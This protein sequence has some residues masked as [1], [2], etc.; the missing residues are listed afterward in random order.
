VRVTVIGHAGLYIESGDTTVLVDPWL[1]GSC[2]WRSWWHFPP[3]PAPE[4]RWLNPTYLYLTHHHFDHFHYPSLRRIHRRA[5]V[6]IPRF[7]NDV[8]PTELGRLG[9]GDVVE[10]DHGRTHH[11]GPVELTSFQYGFDDSALVVA[12]RDATVFDLNDCK[13][14]PADLR[15][16]RR[17]FGR[18]TLMLK[19]HSWAQG[20][21]NC[22]TAEEPSDLELLSRQ[23]YIADFLDSTRA[24]EPRDAAPFASMVCFLHPE[25]WERNQ[26]VVTPVE[27]ADAFEKD[28]VAGTRLIIMKPGDCWAHDEAFTSDTG[29]LYTNRPSWLEKLRE[30][31]APA[32]ERSLQEESERA[33]SP[34][35]LT[36]YF[37]K[38]L[39]ALPR[40]AGLVLR[41]P[42]VF[43]VREHDAYCVLDWRRR[44]ARVEAQVPEDYASLIEV[45]TGV[46]AGAVS[47]RIVH[48]VHISM[49]F[50]G[51]LGR[52]G[53]T[54]D[55]A[56][57][58]LITM[59]ELGYL[60]LRRILTPRFGS[61]VWRRRSEIVGLLRAAV[62]GRGPMAARMTSRF[63]SDD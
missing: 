56:F 12:D 44:R 6:L 48:F 42:I 36:S 60:P 39:R 49:R 54:T 17:R 18:P 61:V 20:Y 21:P 1:S 30:E 3:S 22:Y 27:V 14:R 19:S 58:T 50:G 29:D 8:M 5:R 10:M 24:L 55:F 53:V 40:P 47:D 37:T 45:P 28:P 51:R 26:D 59:W 35:Q 4:E 32:V 57:W 7:G 63:M 13:L 25:T 2:Y 9:F 43:K 34:S 62:G 23:S 46:L 16:L 11:L 15:L 52:Q 41:R 38:F 31:A 33:L